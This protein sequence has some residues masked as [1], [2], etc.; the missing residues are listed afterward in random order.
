MNTEIKTKK[1]WESGLREAL[2][3]PKEMDLLATDGDSRGAIE[4][5]T[6]FIQTL[7]SSQKERLVEKIEGQKVGPLWKLRPHEEGW[8]D[9]LDKAI[10]IIKELK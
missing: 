10:K 6:D 1:E 2:R 7:L 9:G 5:A 4:R 3:W 8:N